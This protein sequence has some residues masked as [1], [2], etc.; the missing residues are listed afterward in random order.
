[1][2]WWNFSYTSY[3]AAIGFNWIKQPPSASKWSRFNRHFGRV[4]AGDP[5]SNSHRIPDGAWLKLGEF[6]FHKYA[7]HGA[8]DIEI[9]TQRCVSVMRR[10][11]PGVPPVW[12]DSPP[13]KSQSRGISANQFRWLW[14]RP[15]SIWFSIRL[16]R[17]TPNIR[18]NF[19]LPPPPPQR[20]FMVIEIWINAIESG[21]PEKKRKWNNE[22]NYPVKS[23]TSNQR[24]WAKE[25][26]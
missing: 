17:E 21:R 23:F 7:G 15:S 13:I 10:L 5:M 3:V 12:L 26:Q 22:R 24:K 18:F 20:A 11:G 2:F 8:F 14:R 6:I 1:M 4:R 16:A 19:Q 9:S 25:N